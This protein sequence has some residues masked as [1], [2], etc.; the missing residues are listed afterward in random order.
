MDGIGNIFKIVRDKESKSACIKVKDNVPWKLYSGNSPEYIDM[1][2]ELASGTAKGTYPLDITADTRSYFMIVSPAGSGILAERI[3]PMSGAFN[4]RDIGGYRTRDGRQVKWGKLFRSGEI[5]GLTDEDRRYL[6]SIPITSVVDFRAA[7]E[8]SSA[9]D[10]LPENAYNT[11]AFPIIPGNLMGEENR[12]PD[13]EEAVKMMLDTNTAFASDLDITN[14]FRFFFETILNKDNTPLV[15][16]CSAG[17]DRT[18]MAAALIL[19]GLGVDETTV[20]K[21]YMLSNKC[22]VEKYAAMVE[23]YPNL[24]PL[25]EVSETYL[26]TALNRIKTDHGSIDTYLTD[27]LGVDT[28]LLKQIYLY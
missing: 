18:G 25:I 27:I 13:K 16:H 4:F 5:S 19:S 15:F 17:K 23:R 9:P 26:E 11:Y 24:Q 10:I 21:D 3:L 2:H 7:A 14:Q 22:T 20:M 12:L 1:E 6:G 28:G 8:A